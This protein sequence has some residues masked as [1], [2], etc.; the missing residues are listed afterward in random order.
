VSVTA[1][2]YARW[3]EGNAYRCPLDLGEAEVLA[4]LLAR[5]AKNSPQSPRTA[6]NV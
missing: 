1:R 5:L 4:D 3:A 2:H 6:A